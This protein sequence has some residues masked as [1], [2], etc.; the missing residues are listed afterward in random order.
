[1]NL[2]ESMKWNMGDLVE[3]PPNTDGWTAKPSTGP[4]RPWDTLLDNSGLCLVHFRERMTERSECMTKCMRVHPLY[5][6]TTQRDWLKQS[7]GKTFNSLVGV[8]HPT[9]VFNKSRTKNAYPW[10]RTKFQEVLF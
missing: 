5:S 2:N 4:G 7:L 1:M 3:Q 10:S 6:C 9:S 8:R